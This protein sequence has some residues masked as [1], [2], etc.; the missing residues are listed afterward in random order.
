MESQSPRQGGW[1]AFE[2]E[3]RPIHVFRTTLETELKMR[4][5]VYEYLHS[6]NLMVSVVLW[7]ERSYVFLTR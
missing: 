3:L 1:W 5:G 4:V 7:F 2:I 6:T